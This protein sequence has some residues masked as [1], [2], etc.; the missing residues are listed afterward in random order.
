MTSPSDPR[1][2]LPTSAKEHNK[3]L[4]QVVVDQEGAPDWRDP[5]DEEIQSE[6]FVDIEESI[7]FAL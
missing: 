2:T 4:D 1:A 3:K 5:E 6:P 7:R